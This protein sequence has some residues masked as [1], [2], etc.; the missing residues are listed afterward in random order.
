M[1]AFVAVVLGLMAAVAPFT[2]TPVH[3]AL[4][5]CKPQPPDPPGDCSGTMTYTPTD[6]E[7]ATLTFTLNNESLASGFLTAFAF[8]N[9]FP[10]GGP[11]SITGI[12]EGAGFPASFDV[13]LTS[14]GIS[15]SPYGDFDIL[16]SA[17]GSSFLGG[18]SPSG[19]IPTGGSA[20]FELLLTGTLLDTITDATFRSAFSVNNN[21]PEFPQV[22]GAVRYRGFSEGTPGGGSDKDPL[23]GIPEEN[24]VPAPLSLVLLATGVVTLGAYTR[25]R[26]SR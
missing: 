15:G 1:R 3:A 11:G 20:T 17:S 25:R 14:N 21:D 22:W 4:I 10:D 13:F 8:N 9:P 18:G 6:A 24:R 2:A 5:E 19:G 23:A 16:V 26:L 12:Q 7:H